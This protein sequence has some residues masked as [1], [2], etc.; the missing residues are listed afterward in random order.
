MLESD[1]SL[2]KKADAFMYGAIHNL[3]TLSITTPHRVISSKFSVVPTTGRFRHITRQIA[4]RHLTHHPLDWLYN[5][6]AICSLQRFI[7]SSLDFVPE[8][9]LLPW[10]HV[11]SE[12][13]LTPIVFSNL[14]GDVICKE[15][16]VEGDVLVFT[17]GSFRDEKLG[18]SF[19]IFLD[20]ECLFPIL[21]Y[22]ALLNPRKTIL[23]AEAI[24]LICGLDA[25][26]TLSQAG[27]T[28]YVISDCLA[29]QHLLRPDHR[30]A[31]L[32]YLRPLLDLLHGSTTRGI[33]C[34]WIK[35]HSNHPSTDL[36]DALAKSAENLNDCFPG[37]SHSY[38]SLH[39]S[40]ASL[41]EWIAWFSHVPHYDSRPPRSHIK[42]HRGLKRIESSILFRLR[43]NKC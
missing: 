5:H 15:K 6:L 30:P 13:D 39:L 20:R 32:S 40:T 42:A 18:Y 21:E 9:P 24:A 26:L 10:F 37:S 36:V 11:A 12:D 33:S 29:A 16:F 8:D 7:R 31:P 35:G 28:I 34:A 3:F 38:L 41:T 25:A 1:T 22:K 27:G 4:A 2:T 14:T 19:C 43:G 17:D 23:E